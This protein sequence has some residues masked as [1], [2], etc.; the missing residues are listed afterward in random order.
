MLTWDSHNRKVNELN[1]TSHLYLLYDKQSKISAYEIQYKWFLLIKNLSFT[2][3]PPGQIQNSH[4]KFRKTKK[5]KIYWSC[6]FGHPVPF[7]LSPL[8]IYFISRDW[9]CRRIIPLPKQYSFFH[10]VRKPHYKSCYF[11]YPLKASEVKHDPRLQHVI[12]KNM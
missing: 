11:R 2:P 10:H 7:S 6:F 1:E 4:K 9:W 3:V 5:N 8:M 12:S